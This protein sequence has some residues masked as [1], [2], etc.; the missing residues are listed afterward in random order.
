MIKPSDDVAREAAR[1]LRESAEGDAALYDFLREQAANPESKP[2]PRPLTP[3]EGRLAEVRR[4]GELCRRPLR[5]Q[6][7]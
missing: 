1:V 4:V 7:R 2:P 3:M 5:Q 6:D